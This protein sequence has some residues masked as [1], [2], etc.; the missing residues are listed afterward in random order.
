VLLNGQ[1]PAPVRDEQV[2]ALLA[3]GVA[4]SLDGAAHWLQGL[5]GEPV[6]DPM[7]A[8][9]VPEDEAERLAELA[10]LKVLDTPREETYDRFTR[11]LREAFGTP[12]ALV[13]LVDECRQ[14]WKASTGLPESLDREREAPRE[15]SICGHVVA[16]NEVLVI[17]DVLRDKRFANNPF[18]R[19]HGIRFYAGAPLR[20]SNGFA[21]GSLCVLD[22]KPRRVTR[23]ERQ[24]LELVADEVVREME[25]R[26]A[27]ATAESPSPAAVGPA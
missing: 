4:T 26:A 5:A 23:T 16:A 18:L 1:L 11:R 25:Q 3:D 2:Q 9:P 21:V 6:A 13:S 20:T 14:W 8:P 12:V 7:L 15:T 17:E 27:Q 22:T 24:L 19:Q 10:R